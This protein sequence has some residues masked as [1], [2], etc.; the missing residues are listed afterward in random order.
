MPNSNLNNEHFTED[1]MKII[2]KAWDAISNVMRKKARN[3]S[4][5]ERKTYGS[6][7]EENKLVVLKVLDYEGTHPHLKAPEVDYD[8]L[9][10]D[11]ADRNF[12][13]GF[14]SQMIEMMNIANNIRI[15]HDYDAYQNS[16]TDY[17]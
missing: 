11:W 2:A 16:R 8:E 15:T 17:N 1:E 9:K 13:A 4:P 7:S 10:A 14:V 3:L 6:V 12:L 5:E